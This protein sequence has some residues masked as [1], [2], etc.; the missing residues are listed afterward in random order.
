MTKRPT[1]KK[2]ANRRHNTGTKPRK[3]IRPTPAEQVKPTRTGP[4]RE[5][6]NP[7]TV[8]AGCIAA[9]IQAAAGTAWSYIEQLIELLLTWISAL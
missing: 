7:K 6:L 3:G 4:I 5:A 9:I 1:P 2:K 8:V